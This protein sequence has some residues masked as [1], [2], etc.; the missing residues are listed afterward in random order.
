[1]N[2]KF[3]KVYI[4]LG[5]YG[6]FLVL[7]KGLEYFFN[8]CIYLFT[9]NHLNSPYT[10]HAF[11][12]EDNIKKCDNYVLFNFNCLSEDKDADVRINKQILIDLL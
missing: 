5:Y 11:N 4:F 2:D 10:K 6:G 1:M 12:N 8:L 9:K 7:K 3:D